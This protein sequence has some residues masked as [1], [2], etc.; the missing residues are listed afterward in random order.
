MHSTHTYFF[1]LPSTQ[2]TALAAEARE[3]SRWL[4]HYNISSLRSWDRHRAT[5]PPA[6]Q[7]SR[8]RACGTRSSWKPCIVL[9]QMAVDRAS[10][11]FGGVAGLCH[12]CQGRLLRGFCGYWYLGRR[13]GPFWPVEKLYHSQPGALSLVC[14][15][16]CRT[17]HFLSRAIGAVVLCLL[18]T[19]VGE[20]AHAILLEG[21][22]LYNSSRGLAL[23]LEG[24]GSCT[25]LQ[26]IFRG[27]LGRGPEGLPLWL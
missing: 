15:W 5:A 23:L 17:V 1:Q 7:S 26:E 27:S 12:S 20:Y 4:T 18:G 16:C 21:S 2:V 24:S 3:T 19:W 8:P 22:G 10:L 6:H 9:N 25:F 11:S 14:L 13:V